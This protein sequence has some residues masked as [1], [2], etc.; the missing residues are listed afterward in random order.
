[1]STHFIFCLLIS[2]FLL[3]ALSLFQFSL[4]HIC[5]Y[6]LKFH[7][8]HHTFCISHSYSEL[9]SN[10]YLF[11]TALKYFN[12]TYWLF[13]MKYLAI[14]AWHKFAIETGA[15]RSSSWGCSNTL[16]RRYKCHRPVHTSRSKKGQTA[17]LFNSTDTSYR[18]LRSTS[19]AQF[20][21]AVTLA[22]IRSVESQKSP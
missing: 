4:V 6:V 15:N 20:S 5:I 14:H 2:R 9:L 19:R 17:I 1:M 11:E 8:L 10:I 22:N 16:P 21:S 12:M 3:A 18:E 13:V 7:S